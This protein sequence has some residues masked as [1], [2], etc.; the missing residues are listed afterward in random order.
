MTLYTK[1]LAEINQEAF[2]VLYRELGVVNAVRFLR[3]FS[4]GFGNYTAERAI[5]FGDKDLAEIVREIRQGAS[6][7]RLDAPNTEQ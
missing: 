1:S 6:A 3:Q 4:A 5:L 7:P 2:L